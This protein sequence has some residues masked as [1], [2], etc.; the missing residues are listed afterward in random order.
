MALEYTI[1]AEQHAGLEDG[2]RGLYEERDGA[3]VLNVNGLEDTNGLKSALEKER[4]SAKDL[5]KKVKEWEALGA[6]PEEIS[7]LLKSPQKKEEPKSEPAA[8]HE[9][10][11]KGMDELRAKLAKMEQR[12]RDR[13]IRDQLKDLSAEQMEI[14]MPALASVSDEDLPARIEAIRKAFPV[15]QKP[16]PVGGPGGNPGN[17]PPEGNAEAVKKIKEM[18]H[19]AKEA[20]EN[21][22]D[23]KGF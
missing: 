3:F 15:A 2:L 22:G 23:W 17:K 14:V 8:Q 21:S 1:N 20:G 7:A 5:A 19:T 18:A 11:V 10:Y 9:A 13:D 6:S 4:Q 16:G 12:D